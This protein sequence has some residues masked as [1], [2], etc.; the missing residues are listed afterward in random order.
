LVNFHNPA[1]AD[2]A[3]NRSMSSPLL[4]V[5]VSFA[6]VCIWLTVRIINRREQWAI[7]AAV[8]LFV[9]LFLALPSLRTTCWSGGLT[10]ML[11]VEVRDARSGEP[12]SDA[13]IIVFHGIADRGVGMPHPEPDETSP[14]TEHF[15][16]D[17]SGK[18]DGKRSFFTY[19]HEN[20]FTD[21]GRVR[22]WDVLVRVTAANYDPCQVALGDLLGD[23]RDY[24]DKSRI[25]LPIKLEPR[26]DRAP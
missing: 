26:K 22:F 11:K 13:D 15:V 12:V 20:W 8:G 6:A 5:G 19:G 18:A 14:S 17:A 1:P 9:V 21:C 2:I 10:L 23:E 3:Y 25:F 7:W 4:I 24:H 16:S